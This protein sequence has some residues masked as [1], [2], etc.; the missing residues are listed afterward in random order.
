MCRCG[1]NTL[2]IKHIEIE[3]FQELRKYKFFPPRGRTDC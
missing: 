3:I 1:E 2:A